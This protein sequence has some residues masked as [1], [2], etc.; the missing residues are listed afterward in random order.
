MYVCVCGVGVD[1]DGVVC[2]CCV[3]VFKVGDIGECVE[4]DECDDE[5]GEGDD[6]GELVECFCVCVFLGLGV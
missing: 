5:D 3:C 2:F 6:E 4:C 1:D